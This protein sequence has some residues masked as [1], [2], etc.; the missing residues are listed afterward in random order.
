MPNSVS[1]RWILLLGLAVIA[2][3]LAVAVPAWREYSRG[4]EGNGQTDT[5][6]VVN[7]QG[8]PRP[9]SAPRDVPLWAVQLRTWWLND[10]VGPRPASAPLPPPAWFWEW[11]AWRSGIE[12][13]ARAPIPARS[14]GVSLV[15]GAAKGDSWLEVRLGSE[16][17]PLRFLGTLRRGRYLRVSGE[18]VWIRAG[19]A[20]NLVAL[21]NGEPVRGLPGGVATL[22]VTPEGVQTLA[23]G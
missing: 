22:L 1:E 23:L 11:N 3:L 9:A 8:Q 13:E 19:I 10:R 14:D 17:G 2:A 16:T 20:D 15:L 4:G 21:L 7:A 18:Q 12:L 5:A 6:L